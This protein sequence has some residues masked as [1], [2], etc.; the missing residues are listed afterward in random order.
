MVYAR[1]QFEAI[2]ILA[3]IAQSDA[4]I[5]VLRQRFVLLMTAF[6]AAVFDLV[7][8]AFRKNFF[9]LISVFGKQ[10]KLSLEVIAEAGSFES[11][12]DQLIDEQ[13]KKR[14]LKDLLGLLQA[15]GVVLVDEKQGDRTVQLVELVL[16]RN[17]HIHNRGEV[18]ERYLEADPHSK[19]PRY[20]LYDLKIGELARID[21]AYLEMAHRLCG[22]CV[23][24]L[25]E[26]AGSNGRP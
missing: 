13:L 23:D 26:W 12:R 2:E 4:E 19:K 14:Y 9:Q 24:R 18:D 11:L 3:R 10:D 1:E 15:Q 16:R 8:I 25:A 6:D 5:N 17:L 21:P 7:R 22:N 20:N